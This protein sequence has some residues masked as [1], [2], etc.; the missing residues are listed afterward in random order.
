MVVTEERMQKARRE[1]CPCREGQEE[2]VDASQKV[3]R[4]FELLLSSCSTNLWR[5]T[6]RCHCPESDMCCIKPNISCLSSR[7]EMRSSSPAKIKMTQRQ[8]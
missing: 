6:M 5:V 8:G 3:D 1:N 2:C 7:Y 4:D